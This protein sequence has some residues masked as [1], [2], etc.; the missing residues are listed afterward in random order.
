[1]GRVDPVEQRLP[2]CIKPHPEVMAQLGESSLTTGKEI[3]RQLS[4]SKK[5]DVSYRPETREHPAA[6][7]QSG[8]RVAERVAALGSAQATPEAAGTGNSGAVEGGLAVAPEPWG[9]GCG[10][11]GPLRALLGWTELPGNRLGVTPP[12]VTQALGAQNDANPGLRSWRGAWGIA[13]NPG[14]TH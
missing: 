1:M 9:A 6:Q 5:P 4:A 11:T 7:G 12:R 10:V 13:L 2:R 8:R 3:K 14:D